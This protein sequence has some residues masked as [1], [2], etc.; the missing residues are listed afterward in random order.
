MAGQFRRPR[1]GRPSPSSTSATSDACQTSG[2][3]SPH[4]FPMPDKPEDGQPPASRS[5]DRSD[6]LEIG[7]RLIHLP[8]RAPRHR[9]VIWAAQ[10][11]VIIPIDGPPPAPPE[12]MPR[13]SRLEQRNRLARLLVGEPED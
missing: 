12:P 13:M 8:D 10:A 3:T 9:T 5:F 4:P 7:N 11:P 6:E 2:S 1:C